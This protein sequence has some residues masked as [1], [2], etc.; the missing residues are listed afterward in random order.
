M[1]LI[2]RYSTGHIVESASM[3]DSISGF[4]TRCKSK[5]WSQMCVI[6]AFS[7]NEFQ[8]YLQNLEVEFKPVTSGRHNKKI[9]LSKNNL[10]RTIY[11][12]L[13]PESKNSI[14]TYFLVYES[15]SIRDYFT[16]MIA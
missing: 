11:L 15:I 12:L 6:E 9:I 2:S 14:T 4:E 1:D 3:S 16:E 13:K 8:S 10:F 7:A 5:L